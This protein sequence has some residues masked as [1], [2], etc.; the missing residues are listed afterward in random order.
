MGL[1]TG[2]DIC[3]ANWHS[4]KNNVR[5]M[6]ENVAI[7]WTAVCGRTGLRRSLALDWESFPLC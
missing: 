6:E 2:R 3:L 7:E 4:L 1:T 5:A